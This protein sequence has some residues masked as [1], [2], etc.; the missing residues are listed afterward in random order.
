M[1]EAMTLQSARI[2]HYHLEILLLAVSMLSATTM[3]RVAMPST[4]Q[5]EDDEALALPWILRKLEKTP[6]FVRPPSVDIRRAKEHLEG[7]EDQ[8]TQPILKPYIRLA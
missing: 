3:S 4:A 5:D 1:G 2:Y 8:W 7:W 6:N